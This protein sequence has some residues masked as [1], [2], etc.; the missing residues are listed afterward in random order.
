[1]EKPSTRY[2]TA[3]KMICRLRG[4]SSCDIQVD[5]RGEIAAVHVTARAGRAAKQIARDIE[6]IL[7]AEEGISIDHRKISIAQFGEAELPQEAV[8]ALGRIALGGVS[9]H[10]GPTGVEV[11]VTLSSGPVHATG[12][13]SGP[14]TRYEVRRLVAQSTLDAVTKLVEGEP[15]FSLGELEER[16]SGQARGAR[17]REPEPGSLRVE[18]DR[19]LRDGLRSDTIGYL[20]GPGCPQSIARYTSTPPSCRVRNRSDA[21]GVGG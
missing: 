2:T 7:A 6:A 8:E 21:L 15:T 16:T 11:E 14:N 1:V 17:L 9:L 3:E 19:V 10:Q 13:A 20:R 18:P 4:V 12:R 5:A